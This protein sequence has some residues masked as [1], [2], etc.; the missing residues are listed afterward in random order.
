MLQERKILYKKRALLLSLYPFS[1]FRLMA[2]LLKH[3]LIYHLEAGRF[4]E[5]GFYF[6][7][8]VA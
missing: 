2:K 8:G 4:V 6:F 5:G 1:L 3:Y 7:A